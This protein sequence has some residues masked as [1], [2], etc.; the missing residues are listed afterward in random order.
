MSD[1][2]KPV[3]NKL[4]SVVNKVSNA[5]E[6]ILT[7]DRSLTVLSI[8]LGVIIWA[9]ISV[10]Q[11]PNIERKYENVPIKVD[12]DGSYAQSNSLEAV[13][14]SEETATVTIRGTRAAIGNLKSTDLVAYADIDNVMMAKTYDLQM[15]VRASDG[16]EFNVTSIYPSTVK[17]SFDKIISKEIEVEPMVDDLKT[18]AG[19]VVGDIQITPATVTV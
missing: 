10:A 12:L 5:G 14:V 15:D 9:V 17:V 1:K 8:L 6:S 3:K 11:F 7:S 13:D 18:A 4:D 16:R 19:Y 2:K